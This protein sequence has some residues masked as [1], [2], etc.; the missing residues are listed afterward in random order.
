MYLT[1]LKKS[2]QLG[3]HGFINGINRFLTYVPSII[4]DYPKMNEWLALVLQHLLDIKVLKADT[5]IINEKIA[6]PDYKPAEDEDAP[7][8]DDYYRLIGNLLLLRS[9]KDPP[10]NLLSFFEK[11]TSFGKHFARMKSLILE[12]DLF[13]SIQEDLL[14]GMEGEDAVLSEQKAKVIRAILEQDSAKFASA[15]Q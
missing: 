2:N 11:E 3:I 1:D 13:D 9:R 5:I 4:A 8:V 7:V 10:N 6:K 15:V 12:D 14:G